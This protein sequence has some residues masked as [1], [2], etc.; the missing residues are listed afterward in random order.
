[1]LKLPMWEKQKYALDR[2]K[3]RG[4]KGTG[5]LMECGTGKTRVTIRFI[6]WLFSRG[7][8][9]GYIV[10]PIAA[11]HVWVE[12]WYEWGN[13]HIAF[14]DLHETGSAGVRYAHRLAQDGWPVICLVNYEM[15]WQ[16][17]MGRVERTRKGNKVKILEIVDTTMAD[18][19]W[20]FGILDESSAIKTPGSKASKFFRLKMRAKTT[21]RAVLNGTSYK[22]R[23][24]DVWAQVKFATG[25]EIFPG[26][27]TQFKA[28]YAIPHPSIRGAVV[29]YQ[30][31]DDLVRRLNKCCVLVKK[32]EMVDIPPA[33][34][35][36][37]YAD[38]SPKTRRFYDTLTEEMV[39]ELEEF[40]ENG[41]IVSVNH[42]FAIMRK[43]LQICGGFVFPDAEFD[44]DNP[45]A[46]IIRPPAVRLGT[47]KLELLMQ[48]MED[49]TEPTVI[50]TQHNEEEVIIAE[51]L[52]KR[53]GFMPKILNGS[54]KGAERRHELIKAASN[55]LAFIVKESVG[56]K[57]ID[58]R[59]TDMLIYFAH[60]ADTEDYD[61]MLSRPHRGGQTKN[62]TY[63]HLLC[64]DSADIRVM[65]ILKRDLKLAD[66]IERNWRA[67][68][69]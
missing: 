19:Q 55:D 49:R 58:L 43:Q 65:K 41:G 23:P 39:A 32:E 59:W 12:G 36:T 47:E 45:D 25:E 29:G 3:K 64:R 62:V 27:F 8:R 38:L 51:A 14:V 40:E 34:H 33:T 21:N 66:Q 13:G 18:Y 60:S 37:R 5:L 20:D 16:I 56:A 48:I 68:L 4:E 67:L 30:N 52:R 35:E 26:N 42:I 46:K 9:I 6:E 2:I 44:E 31:L 28:M 63:M 11:L 57:G 17:G 50:V 69:K 1:M 10:G 61:Q 24:L 7:A 15:A 54:I 53:F 22:K